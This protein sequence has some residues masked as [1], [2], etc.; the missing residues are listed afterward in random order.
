M[1]GERVQMDC[2]DMQRFVKG[3]RK[4][5]K[6]L[7]SNEKKNID[8]RKIEKE[9]TNLLSMMDDTWPRYLVN[10]ADHASKYGETF[11]S[12]SKR[13]IAMA[14][15]LSKYYSHV[16][17]SKILH[18]DNGREFISLAYDKKYQGSKYVKLTDEESQE[19]IRKVHATDLGSH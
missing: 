11:A 19:V 9:T 6:R 4:A 12:E 2:I 16:G 17:A 7:P 13:A 8:Y 3:L 1:F 15:I 10:I 18:T 5:Y 14:W